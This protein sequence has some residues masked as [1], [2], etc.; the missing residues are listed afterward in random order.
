MSK[1]IVVE[2]D[3]DL[4]DTVLN[5]LHLSGHEAMGVGSGSEMWRKLAVAPQDIVVLDIGL[6]DEDGYSIAAHLRRETAMGIIMLTARGQAEDRI[7]GFEMGADIYLVKP[8]S[9]RELAAAVANLSRRLETPTTTHRPPPAQAWRLD[10]FEWR[11]LTPTGKAV[12]LTPK[13]LQLM[14][15]LT[16]QAGE[17]VGRVELLAS[18]GYDDAD[19]GNRNLDALVRRLRRKVEEETEQLLPIQT[20]HSV[21]YVFSAP[22]LVD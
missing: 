7:Q 6:P 16:S 9:C 19:P 2:D 20:V 4:R 21:G 8:V 11:L 5:C 1:V 18:V 3:A 13:E 14:K 10:G 12:K 22:V 15:R 17:P